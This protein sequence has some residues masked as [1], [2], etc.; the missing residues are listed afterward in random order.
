MA[1]RRLALSGAAALRRSQVR[2]RSTADVSS[3]QN[4]GHPAARIPCRAGSPSPPPA[5]CCRLPQACRGTPPLLARSY[6]E[7]M[8]PHRLVAAA[9]YR[10]TC[11]P[12]SPVC[13]RAAAKHNALP[14]GGSADHAQPA[15]GLTT[16][17]PSLS[18]ADDSA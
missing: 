4:R 14:P 17:A 12:V 7:H 8:R 3:S 6:C 2:L 9:P 11:Q 1:L 10:V 16:G 15:K 13:L 5:R 18:C